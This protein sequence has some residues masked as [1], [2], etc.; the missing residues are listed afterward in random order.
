MTTIT[1]QGYN[2]APNNDG[3]VAT[4]TRN[5][6]RDF[7]STMKDF[8]AFPGL[9][10][11]QMQAEKAIGQENLHRMLHEHQCQPRVFDSKAHQAAMQLVFNNYMNTEWDN[12]NEY[13]ELAARITY[14]MEGM[15]QYIRKAMHQ[16]GS[17]FTLDKAHWNGRE[18]GRNHEQMLLS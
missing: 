10:K 13:S 6:L 12:N 2:D 3:E 1:V 8:D 7:I 11:E 17:Q 15:V 14:R 18:L 5:R 4:D 9:T 16:Q